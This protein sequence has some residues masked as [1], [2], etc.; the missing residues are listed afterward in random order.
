MKEAMR[1]NHSDDFAEALRAVK[2]EIYNAQDYINNN[3]TEAIKRVRIIIYIHF[4][5]VNNNIAF[6]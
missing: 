6:F 2:K 5:N 4:P 3:G 1:L